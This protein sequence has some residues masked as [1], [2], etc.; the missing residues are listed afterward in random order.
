MIS[1]S[2]TQ[3]QPGRDV[4]PEP[5]KVKST[6]ARRRAGQTPTALFIKAIF[7][8]IFKG[9]YYLLHGIRTHKLVTLCVIILLLGSIAATSYFSTGLLPFGIGNDPFNFHVHGTNGGGDTV[10]NWLYS[11]RD[12]DSSTMSLIDKNISQPPNPDQ[13]IGQFSQSKA[14][15]TWKAINVAGVY[16]EADGTVDSIVE[17][18]LSATGPGGNVSGIMIWHFVTINQGGEFLLNVNLVDFRAPLR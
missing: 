14:H 11:L 18:D 8:P 12:G 2:P 1:P 5:K 15:L 10:K 6:P 13:L 4:K 17:V 9:I 7:R 16:S 3:Q